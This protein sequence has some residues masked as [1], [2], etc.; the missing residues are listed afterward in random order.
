MRWAVVMLAGCGR[1]GFPEVAPDVLP[2]TIVQVAAGGRNTCVLRADGAVD[3][4]GRVDG[5]RLG[6]GRTAAAREPVPARVLLSGPAA[7]L[8]IGDGAVCALMRD[9][10]LACWGGNSAGQ[11]GLGDTADR[12][13]PTVVPGMTDVLRLASGTDFTCLVRTDGSVWCAGADDQLGTGEVVGRSTYAQVPG[14]DAIDI[15]AGDF[16]VCA[17]LRSGAVTC[18]GE[19]GFQQLGDGTMVTQRLPQPG[20]PGPYVAIRTGDFHSCGVTAG[21]VVECWGSNLA[22]ELGDTGP[23]R[24]TASAV[25][26]TGTVVELTAGSLTNCVRRDD[27][28]IACWGDAMVGQLGDNSTMARATPGVVPL[29]PAA[30]QISSAT[31]AHTCAL[32]ADG[33]VW[34]WG[35]NFYGECGQPLATGA[36]DVPTRVPGL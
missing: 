12:G 2:D 23:A 35:S 3:C 25:A 20:P 10:T 6:D 9:R 19:N 7:S 18:W 36:L 4:M 17:L 11:L 1:L 16:H 29:A 30:L 15:S 5:G 8:A 31:D 14:L 13:L 27:A 22:F 28:T 33:G 24:G 32:A 34:C 26:N 21:G